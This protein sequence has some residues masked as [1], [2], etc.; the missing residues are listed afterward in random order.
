MRVACYLRVSSL[1]QNDTLQ[2][3]ALAK[4]SQLHGHEPVWFRDQFTGKTMNRPGW[5]SLWQAITAGEL[6]TIAVWKLDRLGRSTLDMANLFAECDA[7]GINLISLTD[8]LDLSTPSGRLMGH[9]LASIAQYERER[10][11]E[12]QKAGI[13]AVRRRHNGKC[14]WGG[15]R[16]GQRRISRDTE[17]TIVQLARLGTPKARIARTLGVSRSTVYDVLDALQPSPQPA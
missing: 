1:D 9:M 2:Q 6:R 3:D 10:N 15:S 16:K 12:R 8:S 17:A 4:W 7:R 13:Q 5:E 14:T 11:L